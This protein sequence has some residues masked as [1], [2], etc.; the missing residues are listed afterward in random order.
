MRC[1][2]KHSISIILY[3]SVEG[4]SCWGKLQKPLQDG[5][6]DGCLVISVHGGHHAPPC[7]SHEPCTAHLM[8]AC[9]QVVILTNTFTTAGSAYRLWAVKQVL[10]LG[11]AVTQESEDWGFAPNLA[12]ADLGTCEFKDIDGVVL[13]IDVRML[14]HVL[15]LPTAD[16]CRSCVKTLNM[17]DPIDSPA[18]HTL[19]DLQ[20][21][22]VDPSFLGAWLQ[23]P[24]AQDLPVLFK[25]TLGAELSEL[26]RNRGPIPM[27]DED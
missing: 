22:I 1:I 8:S 4:Q 15:L 2:C 17:T 16:I 13:A 26:M 21:P 24:M 6:C 12:L 20:V 7:T 10:V 25:S 11:G 18:G 3:G 14:V 19:C 9:M 23:D 5:A 27:Q